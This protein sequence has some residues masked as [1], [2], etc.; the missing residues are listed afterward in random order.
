MSMRFVIDE[1]GTYHMHTY[2]KDISFTYSSVHQHHHQCT[3]NNSHLSKLPTFSL[4]SRLLNYT[5][6]VHSPTESKTTKKYGVPTER[7]V[8]PTMEST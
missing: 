5:Q 3:H 8:N 4:L 1:K 2:I 6:T 7:D